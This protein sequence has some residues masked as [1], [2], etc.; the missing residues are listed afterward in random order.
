[1]LE[2]VP[3]VGELFLKA[4]DE[5]FEGILNEVFV[6]IDVLFVEPLKE[7]E[8]LHY[9]GIL[10]YCAVFLMVIFAG[11]ADKGVGND[12]TC[13]DADLLTFMFAIEA[14]WLVMHFYYNQLSSNHHSLAR[15]DFLLLL[16]F[17]TKLA[18]C[19]FPSALVGPHCKEI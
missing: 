12:A 7:M 15:E 17:Y 13:S 5:H 8:L 1:M 18:C 2:H 4:L 14:Q 11:L 3:K 6:F 19:C 16:Q 9:F 10:D